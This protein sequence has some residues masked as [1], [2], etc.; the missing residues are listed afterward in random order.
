[1]YPAARLRLTVPHYRLTFL[2]LPFPFLHSS[3][4]TCSFQSSY[5]RK[6]DFLST[7]PMEASIRFVRVNTLLLSVAVELDSLLEVRLVLH[8][9]YYIVWLMLLLTHNIH[10][11][12]LCFS[13]PML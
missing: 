3:Y 2:S 8:A 5:G 6:F 13:S 7:L 9:F 1:M 10:L 11:F 12:L 4:T